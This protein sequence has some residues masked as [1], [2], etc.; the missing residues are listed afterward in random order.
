MYHMANEMILYILSIFALVGIGMGTKVIV[1]FLISIICC[2]LNLFFDEKRVAIS[3]CGLQLLLALYLPEVTLLS[4]VW[5]YMLAYFEVYV[6]LGI[7]T[8]FVSPMLVQFDVQYVVLIYVSMLVAVYL[9]YMTRKNE[10]ITKEVK[11]IRDDSE[12]I[13]ILLKDKNKRLIEKQDQEVYVATLKERN[14]IARE[15]HDNVGHILTRTILQMGALMTINREEPLHG[16]LKAVKDSLDV[17]M[18]NIRDSVHDLHDESID[19]RQAIEEMMN[20]LH[21][22][23]ETSLEYD[24]S[25]HVD[26]EIKYVCIGIIREAISNIIKHSSNDYVQIVLREHPGMYQ[27]VIHDYANKTS[28]KE[29]I[30]NYFNQISSGGGIGLRNIQDRVQSLN[31]N[32]TIDAS[33]GFRIFV[34]LPKM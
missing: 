20:D 19:M 25:E 32:L 28:K 4:A 24:I 10:A 30:N 13:S 33:N 17:A 8:A 31:G 34:T 26:K 7:Y 11:R 27:L 6:I 21:E 29:E 22:H 15:I 16:Q 5:M 14:R 12:E 9:S 2:S 18:T 23:Y 1:A 3:F